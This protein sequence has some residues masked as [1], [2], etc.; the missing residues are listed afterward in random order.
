MSIL[1]K[2]ANEAITMIKVAIDLDHNH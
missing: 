1:D 2:C